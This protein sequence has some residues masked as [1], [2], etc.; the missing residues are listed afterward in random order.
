M[1]KH[2]PLLGEKSCLKC[3]LNNLDFLNSA[4][5][6]FTKKKERIRKSKKTRDLRY[7]YQN[8]VLSV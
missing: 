2:V 5:G 7:I 4:W 8:N 3:I 1:G 6:P